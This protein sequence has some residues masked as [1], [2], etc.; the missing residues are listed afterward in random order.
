LLLEPARFAKILL[1][2]PANDGIFD[3]EIPPALQQSVQIG[4]MVVV[5]FGSSLMQGIV[6][7]VS[8]HSDVARIRKIAQLVDPEPVITDAQLQ[9]AEIL[10]QRCLAPLSACVNVLLSEKIR[11]ISTLRY[12]INPDALSAVSHQHSFI[13]PENDPEQIRTQLISL[14]SEAGEGLT[15]RQLAQALGRTK[16]KPVLASLVRSEVVKKERSFKL[17]GSAPIF[18]RIVRLTEKRRIP[19]ADVKALGRV[20]SSQ[21]RRT[22]M[23]NLLQKEDS[24]EIP[25]ADL[26][27]RTGGSQADLNFLEKA[28]LI[29]FSEEELWRDAPIMNESS[30][31][32]ETIQLTAEQ[33]NALQTILNGLNQRGEKKPILIHGV[34][35]SGKTEIYIRA[36][37]EAIA[38]GKQVLM[39]VPEIALTPQITQRFSQRFPGMVGTYHSRLSDGQRYDTWRRG[40]SG[41]FRIIIGPRSALSVPLPDLGL[42]VV[43]ECHDDSY[44]QTEQVPF[45]SAVQAAADYARISNSQL[46]LGSATPTIAQTYKAKM[47]SWHIVQLTERASGIASPAIHLIDM[48]QELK[49]GNR[50][51]FSRFLMNELEKSLAQKKQSILFLNR[52]GSAGYT[53]CHACGHD[54]RCPD[55]DIPLT[56]HQRL[57]TLNCHFC[58]HVEKV[59]GR[60]PV[61]G[62]DEIRQFGTGVEKVEH[63]IQQTFPEA[64]LLRM[65]SETTAAQGSYEKILEDFSNQRADI[66]IGTQMVTKGLDF[67]EVRLV[68]VLLA[69]VGMNFHD[70]RVDE[71]SFQL[72]TQVAGRAGRVNA[73]GIAVLQ[74]FQPERYSIQAAA[75]GNY[76][77]FY[78]KELAYR[79]TL[80]YPPF[81]RLV[82]VIISGVDQKE[83]EADALKLLA[84]IKAVQRSERRNPVSLIG[85]APCFF[86]RVRGKYRWHILLRG[87]NP[88]EIIKKIDTKG[89]T[90]EVDPPS[91]L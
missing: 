11:R 20:Q 17:P 14:L 61:C 29:A 72:L 4:C 38:A 55:C 34:T 74:T 1:D 12:K 68:G 57:N 36:A 84:D 66:L 22:T 21:T 82:R 2:V 51:V 90:V 46:V 30:Y 78:K 69:D 89:F 91:V 77:E 53:F 24:A 56:W 88:T 35:G 48:R 16:W 6:L 63:L 44:Y 65:D 70:Y 49:A 87:A 83:V 31:P 80:G 3:Y 60:C 45:F 79:R 67:P 75:N 54:F 19:V 86:P 41:V 13:E 33:Q 42:I 15:E 7:A 32:G 59:P 5:P 76:Q 62:Q 27:Q 10:S 28:G 25:A 8:T 23:L 18:Q 64:R 85:P 37:A 40:R 73:Q 39:L 47:S 26:L 71:H 50:S 9:L 81:T 43:D 52:R 58:G